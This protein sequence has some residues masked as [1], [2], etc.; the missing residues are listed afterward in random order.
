MR[1]P[2]ITALSGPPIFCA[3]RWYSRTR[4][5]PWVRVS[6]PPEGTEFTWSLRYR[7]RRDWPQSKYMPHQGEREKERR[8]GRL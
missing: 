6:E 4:S 2:G 3:E 5:G 1:T 8:R 7:S